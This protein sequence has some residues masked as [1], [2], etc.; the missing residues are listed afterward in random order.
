MAQLSLRAKIIFKLIKTLPWFF[1][2]PHRSVAE[3]YLEISEEPVK[4]YDLKFKASSLLAGD[5][6]WKGISFL[7]SLDHQSLESVI[8]W[9]EKRRPA[10]GGIAKAGTIEK[11]SAMLGFQCRHLG[12]VPFHKVYEF[13]GA[14]L[15]L[16]SECPKFC[17]VNIMYL[18]SGAA[19]LSL[20]F[21]MNEEV[22]SKVKGIDLSRMRTRQYFLSLNPFNKNFGIRTSES[23]LSK[24]EKIISENS[25]KVLSEI[26]D[27]IR[28]LSGLWSVKI[29]PSSGTV[30][31]D[32][33]AHSA[34][35]LNYFI[36][37]AP[38]YYPDD[39]YVVVDPRRQY[40]IT[41]HTADCTG[42]LLEHD[43]AELLGVDAL[44]IKREERNPPHKYGVS[45]LGGLDHGIEGVSGM[46]HV[47]HVEKML[48]ASAGEV[49]SVFMSKD[50]KS[51]E[52]LSVLVK[53]SLALNKIDEQI[54]ALKNSQNWFD[55]NFK[56]LFLGR[57]SQ[58][59][60]TFSGLRGRIQRRRDQAQDE[61]QLEH[62]G[63][64]KSNA[65]L[66]GALAA[67]QILIALVAVDWSEGGRDKNNV[68]INWQNFKS[69]F[70]GD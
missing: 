60:S 64:T 1:P 57:V 59:E 21:V 54:D 28:I 26:S 63:W 70:N 51:H 6:T 52:S 42:A 32:F 24:A 16:K 62:L 13:H 68:Y 50:L 46:Q 56:A 3:F 4:D 65:W 31:S 19:Y 40:F 7:F 34:E 45:Y 43:A 53:Q 47:I 8:K 41:G 20:Y 30:I 49:S 18:P 33:V 5:F 66:I 25:K 44:F 23:R 12:L 9:M 61:V 55:K 27:V 36:N 15:F 38:V 58:L 11:S 35:S 48:R 10:M 14:P 22:T 69:H 17:D 29:N 2:K 37:K 67:T 39:H